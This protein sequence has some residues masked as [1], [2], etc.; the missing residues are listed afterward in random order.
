MEL[1][2][3]H[4]PPPPAAF[5][6]ETQTRGRPRLSPRAF[7]IAERLRASRQALGLTIGEVAE[8]VGV[9]PSRYRSW[10][11]Q[12]GLIVERDYLPQLARALR[13]RQE[14]IARGVS[15]GGADMPDDGHDNE[16]HLDARTRRTCAKRAKERRL[17]LK[18]SRA[19][20][21]RHIGVSAQV[22]AAWER[23]VPQKPKR[24]F[25][26]RW[27]TLLAVPER[28]IRVL[29]IDTPQVPAAVPTEE[30]ATPTRTVSDEIRLA[31]VWLARSAIPRRTTNYALL[32]DS[33]KRHAEVFAM[34]YGVAGEEGSTLQRIGDHYGVTRERA[35]QMTAK[36]TDRAAQMRLETPSLDRLKDELNALLPASLAELDHRFRG[37]LG[38]SLSIASADRFCREILGRKLVNVTDTPSDRS[39]R[40]IR[41]ALDADL[42]D[43]EKLSAIRNASLKMI[44]VCG[45][46][47]AY[48]VAGAVGESLGAGVT[49]AEVLRCARLVPGFQPLIDVDGWYWFGP[50]PENRLIAVAEKVVCAAEGRA[51]AE[52]ILAAFLRSRRVNYEQDKQVFNIAPALS[53]VVEVLRSVPTLANPQYDDFELASSRPIEALLSP[54]EQAIYQVM[55]ARGN[56]ASRY[57]LKAELVHTGVTQPMTLHVALATS[58]IIRQIERGVFALRGTAIDPEALRS[59]K[60]AVGGPRTSQTRLEPADREGRLSLTFALTEYMLRTRFFTAPRAL[61]A[62]LGQGAYHLEGCAEPVAFVKLRDG[63]CRF[64]KLIGVLARLGY[65]PGDRIRLQID[66][67][68]RVLTCDSAATQ[69]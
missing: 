6:G 31:G 54:T 53:V 60:E 16:P 68:L 25:E 34:R 23:M 55:K 47:Q 38:E 7:E 17:A 9:S 57:T 29:E 20:V 43:T 1:D 14:W 48:F 22:L 26:R 37:L 11:R 58:P 30:L 65:Q 10:E 52:E 19:E 21:A 13:T 35:R 51:D 61:S 2:N 63:E 69:A 67:R 45:A 42:H 49:A 5:S 56:V 39:A 8:L 18:L 41:T 66:P 36:L 4:T 12:A 24:S 15:E 64:R 50:K 32:N 59:E 28:W 3:A 46:A 62:H 27:E 44:R 40:Y 33:E